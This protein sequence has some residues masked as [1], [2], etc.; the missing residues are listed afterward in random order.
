ME[1]TLKFKLA[2]YLMMKE[3]AFAT[4]LASIR[5]T[6]ILPL[7]EDK[8]AGLL[9][10]YGPDNLLKHPETLINGMYCYLGED[11][12]WKILR[13]V[14]KLRK[15]NYPLMATIDLYAHGLKKLEKYD[16][17]SSGEIKKVIGDALSNLREAELERVKLL[18]SWEIVKDYAHIPFGRIEGS[19]PCHLTDQIYTSYYD[20]AVCV[21]ALIFTQI[22]RLDLVEELTAAARARCDTEAIPDEA[23]RG[24]TPP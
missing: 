17:C 7:A 20:H 23:R 1:L 12:T 19:S 6:E 3:E 8:I 16:G 15:P 21:M 5:H 4:V 2:N 10:K 18:L 22:Q 24:N 14:F 11:V 9:K 13:G